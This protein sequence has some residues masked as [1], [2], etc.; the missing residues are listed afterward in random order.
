M[1]S[2]LYVGRQRTAF[3]STFLSAFIRPIYPLPMYV[4]ILSIL[5]RWNG[6]FILGKINSMNYT[7]FVCNIV[8]FRHFF[9]S[10]NLFTSVS[11]FHQTNCVLSSCFT[12]ASI[13]YKQFVCICCRA[14]ICFILPANAAT[15][16]WS[17]LKGLHFPSFIS[18]DCWQY[19][20]YWQNGR[21]I[22]IESARHT[23]QLTVL[24]KI[25]ANRIRRRQIQMS[26]YRIRTICIQI[27][28]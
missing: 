6:V 18:L 3:S 7:P 27:N 9:L 14:A 11:S 13:F 1:A 25:N 4:C 24:S 21:Q 2:R 16:I 5:I 19:F 10:I 23:V 22:D 12:P 28:D 20:R 15:E 8:L 17:K 26:L